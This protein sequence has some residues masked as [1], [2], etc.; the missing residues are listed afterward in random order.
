MNWM[1]MPLRRYADFQG[2]SRRK[3]FWMWQ[4][5][6]IIIGAVLGIILSIV[7][8]SAAYQ[9]AQE[10]DSDSGSSYSSS[11]DDDRGSRS[12]DDA[13]DRESDRYADEDRGGRGGQ[14][15]D[16]GSD[17]SSASGPSKQVDP[18]AFARNFGAGG[19]LL[20]GLLLLYSL[21]IAIPSL[22]VAIRRLH[23]QDKSGWFIFI[24]L[25][26]FVGGIIVLVFY[27]LEGTRG[28]NRFG[29]DPKGMG[30]EQTFR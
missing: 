21:A 24:G 2:R 23:D 9:A 17:R 6:N 11:R 26:P 10:S 25:I 16:E 14:D 19:W 15:G 12:D 4:L 5:L 28:P 3:E 7:V 8:G 27:C 29:P 30:H 22:A 20:I 13:I 1:L 18:E